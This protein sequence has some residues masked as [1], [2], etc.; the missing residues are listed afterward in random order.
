MRISDWSSDVCS[1]DLH[2]SAGATAAFVDWLTVEHPE[3]MDA[4]TSQPPEYLQAPAVAMHG[5]LTEVDSRYGS[6]EGLAATLGISSVTIDQLRHTLLYHPAGDRN[7]VVSGQS[8][9][10]PVDLGGLRTINTKQH[11]IRTSA[12]RCT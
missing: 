1:S 3:Y 5:F 8:V 11:Q 7:L 4:M 9:S 6:L 2:A 12:K 10:D